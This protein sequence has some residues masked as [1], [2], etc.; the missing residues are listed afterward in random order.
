MKCG[1]LI[2]GQLSIRHQVDP[3]LYAAV[4]ELVT[5][6]LEQGLGL[7]YV[8]EGHQ[9]GIIVV[10]CDLQVGLGVAERGLCHADAQP[11][12]FEVE[13]GLIGLQLHFLGEVAAGVLG[14]L[15]VEVVLLQLVRSLVPIRDRHL[16]H[17]EDHGVGLAVFEDGVVAGAA[18]HH[19]RG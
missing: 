4:G 6:L 12:L 2:L 14:Y 1:F 3:I 5:A 9:S 13:P 18:A 16:Q 7:E 15:G 11:A 19:Q 8:G 17:G 10:F